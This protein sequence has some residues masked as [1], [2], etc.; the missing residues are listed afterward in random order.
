M[1]CSLQPKKAEMILRKSAA[2]FRMSFGG[3]LCCVVVVD[4]ARFDVAKRYE[5]HTLDR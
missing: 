5:C 1:S 4:D 3:H 2:A